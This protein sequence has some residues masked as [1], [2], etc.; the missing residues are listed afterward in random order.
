MQE[1]EALL[2]VPPGL[3]NLCALEELDFLGCWV[4]EGNIGFVGLTS[5]KKL[6]LALC[7]LWRSFSPD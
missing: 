6:E 2:E 3:S 7:D 5:L 4:F 1:C